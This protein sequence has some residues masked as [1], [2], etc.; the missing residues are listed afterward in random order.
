MEYSS[1]G[2]C[3]SEEHKNCLAYICLKTGFHCKYNSQC[4]EDLVTQMPILVKFLIEDEKT[5]R[6]FTR[7]AEK[8]CTSKAIHSQCACFKLFEQGIHPPAELLPDGTKIRLKDL[9]FKK[10][11][12]VE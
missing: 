11:I 12:F 1:Y 9:L 7:L 6:L 8:Y 3:A 10:E 2:V 4:L 5:M